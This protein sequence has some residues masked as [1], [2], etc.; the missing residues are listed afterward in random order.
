MKGEIVTVET[1]DG[2]SLDGILARP[3]DLGTSRLPI[4]IVIMHHGVGGRFY[5]HRVFEPLSTHILDHGCTVLCVNSRGHDVVYSAE[6]RG[7][8]R[9]LGAAY[10]IVDDCRYDWE[11]WISFAAAQG[12]QRIGLWGH[13][14]GAVKTIYYL[15]VRADARVVCGIASSPPRQA[16]EN[17]MAQPDAE[18]ALFEK[19][20]APAR[21][22]MEEGDPGRLIQ[23]A[24]RRSIPFTA[25]T[26]VDKYGPGSRY[27]IFQYIPKVTTPLLVTWGGLEPLPSNTSHVSFY[28]LPEE[29]RRHAQEH[30]HIRFAEIA[31][32][33]HGYT[34]KTDQLWEEA[35][36][37]YAAVVGPE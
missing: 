33:D 3:A 8:P 4:D 22:A 30:R 19:D 24:Y 17:Y 29:A 23:T 15:A 5:H 9:L 16:Y 35:R 21:Q 34:G 26:F 31:G 20:Y 6:V 1:A 36:K 27:D 7:Q 12:Y 13:S 25:R 11:A 18:R 37:W 28:Q 10:E 32:A 14:L 2:V